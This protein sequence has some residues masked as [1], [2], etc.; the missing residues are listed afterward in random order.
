VTWSFEWDDTKDALNRVKHGVGFDEAQRAFL[1]SRRIIAVD[2]AHSEAE[3]RWF[4]L[5]MVNGRV[6]TVRFTVRG[7][8]IWII[9]AVYWRKGRRAYE[10]KNG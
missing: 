4:C 10:G 6:I 7:T 3:P 5:G 2:E 1:D 8:T 9:G